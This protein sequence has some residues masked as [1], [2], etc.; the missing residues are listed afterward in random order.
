MK[1]KL[2]PPFI[3]LTAGLITS[4]RTFCLHYDMKSSLIILL[5]VLVVFYVLGS[6]FKYILD[7]FEKENEQKALDE[8]EVFEKAS[9]D[10][11]ELGNEA[12]DSVTEE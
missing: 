3:M 2:L 4:I 7:L 12:V 11:S 8:G 10:E 6:I 5:V 9:E 1:R